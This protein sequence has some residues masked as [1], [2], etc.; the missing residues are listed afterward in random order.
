MEKS[1]R[2]FL[3]AI[4]AGL[5]GAAAGRNTYGQAAGAQ[6]TTPGA[7]PTTGTQSLVGPEISPRTLK[8]AEKLVQFGMTTAKLRLRPPL[9]DEAWPTSMSAGL[10]HERCNCRTRLLRQ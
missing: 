9:G 7:P 4:S 8:E 6:L 1:R 10:D 3:T 5:I 2:K